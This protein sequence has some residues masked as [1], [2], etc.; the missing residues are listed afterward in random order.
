MNS[1]GVSLCPSAWFTCWNLDLSSFSIWIVIRLGSP[2]FSPVF[3]DLLTPEKPLKE[4]SGLKKPLL[5]PIYWGP[6]GKIPL[7]LVVSGKNV[8]LPDTK[9]GMMYRGGFH[10]FYTPPHPGLGPPSSAH[11]MVIGWRCLIVCIYS[12]Y[13]LGVAWRSC[14]MSSILQNKSSWLWPFNS[15]ADGDHL[16]LVASSS[17]RTKKFRLLKQNVDFF[18]TWSSSCIFLRMYPFSW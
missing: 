9:D 13:W 3:L 17:S 4:L 6:M 18:L 7:T 11:S 12:K 5:N 2:P 15:P 1:N 10:K 8:Q 16:L 14:K